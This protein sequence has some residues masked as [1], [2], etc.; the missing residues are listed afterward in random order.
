MTLAAMLWG[1]TV[2]VLAGDSGAAR[3]NSATAFHDEDILL[4]VTGEDGELYY[5]AISMLV[6][7]TGEDYE[8]RA[9]ESRDAML[10]RFPGATVLEGAAAEEVTGDLERQVHQYVTNNAW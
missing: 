6:G 4:Q 2:L 9:H 10:A 7:D 3:A 8:A 5:V 1:G